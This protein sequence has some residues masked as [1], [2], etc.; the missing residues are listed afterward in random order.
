MGLLIK[1]TDSKKIHILGTPIE[2]PSLYA[3][4]RWAGDFTGR[5]IE[6]E[7]ATWYDVD[8]CKT[9]GQNILTDVPTGGTSLE[10]K[11]GEKQTID[12]ALICAKE[13][14]DSLGYETEV[15]EDL[16]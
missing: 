7:T 16:D 9:G 12:Q 3:R 5:K 10:L 4:I 11:E 15:T 1:Q 14:F 2:V 6:F 13:Y 8:T